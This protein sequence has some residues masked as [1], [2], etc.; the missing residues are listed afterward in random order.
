[1]IDIPIPDAMK[2]IN[3]EFNKKMKV[4]YIMGVITNFNPIV[5]DLKMFNR[6]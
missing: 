1:L 4:P 5:K 2:D 3:K 6:D